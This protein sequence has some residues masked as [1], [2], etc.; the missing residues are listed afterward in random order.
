MF[1]EVLCAV[2]EGGS[3]EGSVFLC[4]RCS[5]PDRVQTF[6]A[7]CGMRQDLSLNA[8]RFVFGKSELTIDRTGLVFRY[9][10]CPICS[11][12]AH[13]TPVIFSVDRDGFPACRVA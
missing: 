7:G 10:H 11:P 2:C 8:A 13:E 6:C 3:A 1:A 5:H 9:D 4:D 12:D